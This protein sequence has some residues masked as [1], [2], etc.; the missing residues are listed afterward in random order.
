M[1]ILGTRLLTHIHA[2]Y[3]SYPIHGADVSKPFFKPV[4]DLLTIRPSHLWQVSNNNRA[5]ASHA[6]LLSM[7]QSMNDHASDIR[8]QLTITTSSLAYLTMSG[9]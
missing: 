6:S 5:R 7:L 3:N 2:R 4:R 8:I 9:K 1:T